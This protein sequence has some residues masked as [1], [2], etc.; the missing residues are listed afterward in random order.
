M[1][2]SFGAR[3]DGSLFAFQFPSADCALNVK[4]LVPFEVVHEAY[5]LEIANC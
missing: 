4:V 5:T 1:E 3:S 2:L